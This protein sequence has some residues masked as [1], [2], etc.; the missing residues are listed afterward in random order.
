[1]DNLA[2]IVIGV[3]FSGLLFGAAQPPP[4]D[5]SFEAIEHDLVH[6][7]ID[8]QQRALW[9]LGDLTDKRAEFVIG[10]AMRDVLSGHSKAALELEILEAASKKKTPAIQSLL[11]D[12]ERRRPSDVVGKYKETI[13][14][15][16]SFEGY[17]IFTERPDVDCI[18]CH[19][20][21]CQGGQDNGADLS[22]IG[23]IK[24]REYLLEAIVSP[25]QRVADGYPIP[26]LLA[27]ADGRIVTGHVWKEKDG[28]I[29]IVTSDGETLVIPK[30]TVVDRTRAQ[31]PMPSFGGVLSKRELRD[32]IAYLA[33]LG[34]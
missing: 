16:N 15:G 24:A 6:G 31:S 11:T 10:Q 22:D 18:R 4:V 32:L 28:I 26:S 8:E 1:M 5:R 19:R 17:K 34:G 12:Y 27:L 7:N 14:G 20:V 9:L 23:A 33:S 2:Y 30:D 29:G 25:N 13:H 21:N 3:Y